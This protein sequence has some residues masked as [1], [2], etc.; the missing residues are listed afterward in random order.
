MSNIT[1]LTGYTVTV[2]GGYGIVSSIIDVSIDGVMN[3]CTYLPNNTTTEKNLAFNRLVIGN[4]VA[5]SGTI[6]YVKGYFVDGTSGQ[7]V[8]SWLVNFTVNGVD[9]VADPS[10]IQ[11]LYDINATF[12]KTGGEEEPETPEIPTVPHGEIYYKGN[13][14]AT[15]VGGE[16]IVLHTKDFKFLGDIVIK[17]VG[18]SNLISF[19]ID[20]TTYYAEEGMTWADWCENT[21]YNT[22]GFYT[23]IST[24]FI[25]KTFGSIVGFV[26]TSSYGDVTMDIEITSGHPY[27]ITYTGGGND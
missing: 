5:S 13:L 7:Y 16:T 15:I 23:G 21:T 11:W 25:C 22:G 10:F 14:V 27:I 20:G 3:Y 17:N 9:D 19:T 4:T 6:G 26:A 12:E 1:D 18:E 2:P 8:S 24:G